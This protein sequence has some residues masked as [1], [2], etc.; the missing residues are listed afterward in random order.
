MTAAELT[1]RADR[2]KAIAESVGGKVLDRNRD[3]MRIEVPADM[4]PGLAGLWG[5]GN[6]LA[7]FR[8]Q[9]FRTGTE[10]RAWYVYDIDLTPRRMA[11]DTSPHPQLAITVPTRPS[12]G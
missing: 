10:S 2:V 9:E 5:M 8:R 6:F 1:A 3:A 4:A 12:G 7:I 11:V